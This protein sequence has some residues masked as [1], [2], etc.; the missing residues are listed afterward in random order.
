MKGRQPQFSIKSVEL[1]S[2]AARLVLLS[3][4][5]YNQLHS[6]L[7]N[8]DANFTKMLLVQQILHRL[9][10]LRELKL[11]L[12]YNGMDIVGLDGAIHVFELC[13]RSDVDAANGADVNQYLQDVGLLV[14][15]CTSQEADD[16]YY[17]IDFNRIE[18]LAVWSALINDVS[19]LS[20][21]LFHCGWSTDVDDMAKPISTR[22]I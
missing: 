1:L 5:R 10:E 6:S 15:F 8:L 13:S 18:R 16:R 22:C 3:C 2:R 4:L 14:G 20:T 12:V 9:L 21:C 19:S 17:S 11:L 7:I